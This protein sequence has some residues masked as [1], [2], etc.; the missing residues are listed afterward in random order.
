MLFA[1]SF[2]ILLLI[3][4][5]IAFR[6]V[7]AKPIVFYL[8][9]GG[10]FIAF[11]GAIITGDFYGRKLFSYDDPHLGGWIFIVGAMLV[12]SIMLF[13]MTYVKLPIASRVFLTIAFIL[14][15]ILL[16][17]CIYEAKVVFANGINSRSPQLSNE[18]SG[19][20]FL[21]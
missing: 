20:L 2:F 12:L 18:S 5:G 15:A 13:V 7:K 4:G 6:L 19:K 11:A 21:L 14:T 1:Y 10:M 17:M 8:I 16:V 9:M 3:G